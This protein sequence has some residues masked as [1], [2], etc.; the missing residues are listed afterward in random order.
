M[1]RRI[2]AGIVLFSVVMG[3]AALLTYLRPYG[4]A[5]RTPRPEQH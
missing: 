4:I 2:I 5:S 3:T 1:S